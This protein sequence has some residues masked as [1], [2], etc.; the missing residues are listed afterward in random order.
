MRNPLIEGLK[1]NIIIGLLFNTLK[2]LF[3]TYT[4]RK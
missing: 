1:R 2:K 3:R 4:Q